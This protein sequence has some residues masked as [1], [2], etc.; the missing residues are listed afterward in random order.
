MKPAVT[1]IFTK[2]SSL[3]GATLSMRR[4]CPWCAVP[5]SPGAYAHLMLSPGQ[6]PVPPVPFIITHCNPRERKQCHGSI[7]ELN[8]TC[9]ICCSLR[10]LPAPCSL[11]P[12]LP[13]AAQAQIIARLHALG[14]LELSK[15]IYR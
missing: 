5:I 3:P 14:Q 13:S 6:R 11:L 12:G 1:D 2:T 9:L 8:W 4:R 7:C 15:I 10:L